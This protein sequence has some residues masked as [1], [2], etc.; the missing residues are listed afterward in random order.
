M[1]T[2]PWV[3]S[4]HRIFTGVILAQIVITL[5][6]SSFMGDWLLPVGLSLLIASL[7][8]A[9][10]YW[11]PASALTRHVVAAAIQLLTALHIDQTMGLVELHFEIFALLAFLI[12]YR[13]W[14]VIVTSVSVVAVHHILFFV[15]QANG[16]GVYIF[17][18]GYV[19][20]GILLIHAGFAIAE[21]AVLAVIAKRNF[22]EA[23]TALRIRNAIERIVGSKDRVDLSETVTGD[24]EQITR[25]NQLV[26]VMRASVAETEQL[27]D[28][29][30][31]QADELAENTRTLTQMREQSAQ[32][33]NRMVSAIDE[34]ATTIASISEQ[35]QQ[36]RQAAN[37]S[38]DDTS[39]AANFTVKV[40]EG[41]RL[42][43]D[44]VTQASQHIQ[45]LEQKS[46][47]INT[48]VTAINDITRQTNL[49]ALN[50]AIEAARAGEQ[51]RGFAVVADEVR[52][53]ASTTEQNAAE[54]SEISEQIIAEVAESVAQVEQAMLSIDAGSEQ[55]EQLKQ[56]IESVAQR[57]SAMADG[58]EQV[59]L[60]TEQQQHATQE[61]SSSAQSLRDVSEQERQLV[62]SN[63]R[64]AQNMADAAERLRQQVE[65]F[66]I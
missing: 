3:L 44:T 40:N 57:V 15:L 5:V 56:M 47:R 34:M 45:S 18:E 51:G 49:L 4:A 37:A 10:M 42:V 32:Q 16:A 24:N 11:A 58:I 29:V 31:Q 33:V 52:S 48:V 17:A 41:I 27:T 53:L 30:E 65:R 1:T 61:M 55:S 64:K 43:K 22:D 9:M 20:V 60:A 54:I 14:K 38:M 46:S 6:I 62:E 21:G 35:S 12:Y 7:P 36:A 50:A 63:D 25:F 28:K 23:E 13:D 19:T 26:E 8:L 2:Y 59:A 39:Q 66:A